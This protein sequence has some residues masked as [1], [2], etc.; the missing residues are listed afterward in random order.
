[1]LKVRGGFD[2]LEEPFG[3]DH[4]RQF[5]A[6]NL[7]RDLAVM[8]DVMGQIDRGHATGTQLAPRGGSGRP[9]PPSVDRMASSLEARYG[10]PFGRARVT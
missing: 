7:D 9:R 10:L 2:F 1:M 6:Q 8:T 4:R 5:G 3:A